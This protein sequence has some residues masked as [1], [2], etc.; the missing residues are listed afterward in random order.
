[1]LQFVAGFHAPDGPQQLRVCQR[2][3]LMSH[4]E[5]Q[6]FELSGR[7]RDRFPASPEEIAGQIDFTISGS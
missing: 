4:H 3:S 1:M 2:H 5:H 6:Q 7:E